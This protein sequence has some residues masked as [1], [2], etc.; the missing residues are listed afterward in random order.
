MGKQ[1]DTGVLVREK[2]MSSMCS[3]SGKRNGKGA[4]MA[5]IHACCAACDTRPKAKPRIVAG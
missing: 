2:S 4:W 3:C 5:S 1:E